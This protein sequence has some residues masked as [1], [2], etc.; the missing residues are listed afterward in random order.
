MQYCACEREREGG[1]SSYPHLLRAVFFFM[2]L[3]RH[4]TFAALLFSSLIRHTLTH[5][6]TH[7]LTQ[8]YPHDSTLAC[9]Q[10]K[11][12]VS[13]CGGWYGREKI[14]STEESGVQ[15]EEE[16]DVERKWGL[17]FYT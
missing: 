10:S 13:L 5:T 4:R 16:K 15:I 1:I 6:Y 11:R 8:P 17:F 3:V 14:Q 9:N 12:N 2:Y 7:L